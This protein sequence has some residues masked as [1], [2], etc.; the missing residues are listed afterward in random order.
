MVSSSSTRTKVFISYS[1]KDAKYLEQLL[2]HLAYEERNNLIDAWSDKKIAPGSQWRE[3]IKRAIESTKVAVLLISPSF[4]ASKFIAEDELPPLLRAAEKEGAAILSVIVRPSN[5][6]Y[7]DLANFQAVNSPST[8][9]AKM[10]GYQR[11]EIWTKVVREIKR[12]VTTQQAVEEKGTQPVEKKVAQELPIV[13]ENQLQ[14]VVGMLD[15]REAINSRDWRRAEQVLQNY[16]N[17]P[18]ARSSLGLG[19]SREV[20][21]HFYNQL[22]P[23]YSIQREP[24]ALQ[25]YAQSPQTQPA[26]RKS[27]AIHWLEEALRYQDNPEGNVT[28]ALALMYGYSGSYRMI[29]ALQQALTINPNLISYFRLSTNLMMLIYACPDLAHVEEVLWSVNLKLP[30]IDEIQQTL[31]EASDPGKPPYVLPYVEWY[32]VK[33]KTESI[34]G[35]PVKVLISCPNKEGLTYA[36]ITEKDQWTITIPPQASSIIDI[37]TLIPVDEILKQLT[38]IG[39]VLVTLI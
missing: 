30:E 28:A 23:G 37:E 32:A 15:F 11:D 13:Y 16:P 39:I 3:E 20:Q 17:L 34:V 19:I 31:R 35:M 2:E 24:L 1:H 5:F 21:E 14:Q 38:D 22:R 4:L 7:T 25:Y 27:E 12:V 6:E 10:K 36:Q 9:V 18:E 29:F 26:P 33:L 8:P